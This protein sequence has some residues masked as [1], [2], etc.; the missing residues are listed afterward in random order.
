MKFLLPIFLAFF[1]SSNPSIASS[2]ESQSM[3]SAFVHI[4]CEQE[5]MALLLV[6]ENKTPYEITIS[7]NVVINENELHP[8]VFSIMDVELLHLFKKGGANGVSPMLKPF[9][10]D[11]L[12]IVQ[13]E[14]QLGAFGKKFW[15]YR[16]IEK[17]YSFYSEKNYIITAGTFVVPVKYKD[18]FQERVLVRSKSVIIPDACMQ[19][20]KSMQ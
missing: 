13:A 12:R 6:L 19:S 7:K 10:S 9:N 1:F 11:K 2:E 16:G 3:I 17:Y 4:K 20:F 15:I 14:F 8:N 18:G 5:G